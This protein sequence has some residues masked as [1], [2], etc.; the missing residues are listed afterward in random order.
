MSL[1]SDIELLNISEELFNKSSHELYNHLS[2]KYQ[3]QT[4]SKNL[5]DNA[6]ERYC[7]SKFVSLFNTFFI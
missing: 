2:I 1:I 6:P 3:G 4:T 7:F 5:T